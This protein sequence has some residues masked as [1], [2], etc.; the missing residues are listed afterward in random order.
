[1]ADELLELG[2]RELRELFQE[3][4]I[5]PVDVAKAALR[6]IETFK[7]L[8]AFSVVD[9]EYTLAMA[10]DSEK[11]WLKGEPLSEADGVPVS[12]KDVMLTKGW[13]TLNGSLTVDRHQEWSVDSPC[14]AR[15]REAGCV[16]VGKT[17]TSEFGWKGVND[18]PL[19]GLTGN[20]W[21]VNLTPG[22]SSGGSGVAAALDLGIWHAASDAAGSIRIPAAFCGVF[23]FKPTFGVVPLFPFSVFYGLTHHGPIARS[24][25]EIAAMMRLM[26]LRDAR[27][28][29]S[30]PASVCDFGR[31]SVTTVRNMRLGVLHDSA[32]RI[33]LE[34][35]R[36]VED[37]V[38]TLQEMGAIIET[39]EYDFSSLRE[40][41]QVLWRVGCLMNVNQVAEDR[42]H[43]LDPGL[44]N[45]ARLG[46]DISAE[47]F[48]AAQIASVRLSHD[49]QL[50]LSRHRML[51]TP[52]VPILPFAVGADV[53]PDSGHESWLD[54]AP[55]SYPFNLSQ[56][57]AVS[58]PCGLTESGLPTA[59]QLV[60]SRYDDVAVLD[61]ARAYEKACP[62]ARSQMKTLPD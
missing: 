51:V 41:V 12:I 42:R 30:A 43:L 19:N 57:P 36:L 46:E 33:D 6:R 28:P 13:P 22:G 1:M 18:S 48:R 15:F 55:F 54:W 14:V 26:S 7:A 35:K 32:L 50:L 52:T 60:G 25:D 4:Q 3:K 61:V 10:G 20:P 34:V 62:P 58:V 9:P 53:P 47:A 39:V 56:N 21:N 2:S 59:F 31:A 29:F 5:S 44:L 37:A 40:H 11:R 17:S 27:D 8:N 45:M 24:V 49:I 38:S 16:F 23:G